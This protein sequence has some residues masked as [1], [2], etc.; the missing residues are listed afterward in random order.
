[1]K[2]TTFW[3]IK[4][5]NYFRFVCLSAKNE[6]WKERICQGVKVLKELIMKENT[7]MVNVFM[8]KT[9]S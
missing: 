9:E 4:N 7:V 8:K 6:V 2:F 1:M 5:L 3:V